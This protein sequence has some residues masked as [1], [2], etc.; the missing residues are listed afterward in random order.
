MDLEVLQ[1]ITTILAAGLVVTNILI[2]IGIFNDAREIRATSG[3]ELK[4]FEPEVWTLIGL[5][6]SIPGLAVY[7]AMHHS[8]LAK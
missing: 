8:T 6:G 5:F 2:A 1:M 3:K 7:W 4:M